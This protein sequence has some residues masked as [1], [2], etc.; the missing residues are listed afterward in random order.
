MCG[1]NCLMYWVDHPPM[2]AQSGPLCIPVG[3][4]KS[5][6]ECTANYWGNTEYLKTTVKIQNEQIKTTEWIQDE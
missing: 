2:D 6:L 4:V 1:G 3:F 5:I